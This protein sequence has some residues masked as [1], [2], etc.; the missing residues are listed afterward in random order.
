[1]IFS[2]ITHLKTGNL[3]EGSQGLLSKWESPN[4]KSLCNFMFSVLL[5]LTFLQK[6]LQWLMDKTQIKSHQWDESIEQWKEQSR[7]DWR[8]QGMSC[9]YSACAGGRGE[10]VL[11]T[12]DPSTRYTH[13]FAAESSLG[14]GSGT[15]HNR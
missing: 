2:I 3:R 8:R 10:N 7:D 12:S 13:S 6:D 9:L 14:A 4:W 11:S 1:M 15:G 5:Y